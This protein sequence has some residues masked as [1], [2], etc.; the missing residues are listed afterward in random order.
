MLAIVLFFVINWI[1]R[2]QH[3]FSLG[4]TQLSVSSR[5][6]EAPA[7]NFMLRVF[8]PVVYLVLV[9]S[10]LYYLGLERFV[11][12]IWLVI[13]Y[14]FVFRELF[15]LV[16]G[17]F[18]LIDW[19]Y[20]TL[21]WATTI[22]LSYILY[23]N[24]IRIRRNL[25]PDFDTIANEL[26]IV[27]IFFLYAMLNNRRT[28]AREP[29][30]KLEHYSNH[31]YCKYK[32]R[33]SHLIE[34]KVDNKRV[35]A[36]VYAIMIYESFNRPRLVRWFENLLFPQMS[37]TLG[38]MQVTTDK[39]ISDAESVEIAT[40]RISADFANAK[41][42]AEEEYPYPSS[43]SVLDRSAMYETIRSYNNDGSYIS[44]IFQLHSAIVDKFYTSLSDNR[45]EQ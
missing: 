33:F 3:A 36:L 28:N 14:Y 10:A 17:R 41:Q 42:K 16:L 8:A 18:H 7:F 44:E 45:V 27:V 35:E 4:Y 34:P 12:N 19:T 9:A 2:S 11:N 22:L 38:I 25:L 26:W 24:V 20:R 43:E 39:R 13:V 1:G 5:V 23:D 6:D 40:K 37:K 31:M 29:D 21:V 32:N 15:N 30:K